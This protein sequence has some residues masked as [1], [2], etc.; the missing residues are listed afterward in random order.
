M[1]LIFTDPNT[2]GP[3]A[4]FQVKDVTTKVIKLTQAN[5]AT[6]A[7]NSY[8]AAFPADSSI[9]RVSLWVKTQ[10]AGGGITAAT[11][12][13]GTTSGGTDLMAANAAA[14][15][16]AGVYSVLS[17]VT[18]ILQPYNPPMTT[19]VKLYVSGLATTGTPTSG[20]MYLIVE[21]VR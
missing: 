18:N 13:L 8:V 1:A 2:A 14:F 7:V 21:Y 19:D 20:E 9:L 12:A 4:S 6:S 3:F 11:I 16:A 5:F 10:L 17:P 15:G